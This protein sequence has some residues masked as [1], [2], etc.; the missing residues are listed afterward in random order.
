MTLKQ[1]LDQFPKGSRAEFAAKVGITPQYLSRIQGGV[2]PQMA[3]AIR[4]MDATDGLVSSLKDWD[5]RK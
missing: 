5:N 1:Y 3:T 4:I 2:L